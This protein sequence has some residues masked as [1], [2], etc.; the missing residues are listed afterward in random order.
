MEYNLQQ[1]MF[2]YIPGEAVLWIF[3]LL[4]IGGI[5]WYEDF[6]AKNNNK[7]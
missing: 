5:N 3:I 1:W 7:K 6:K 4:I 2:E